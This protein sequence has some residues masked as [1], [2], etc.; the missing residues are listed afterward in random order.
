M[1]TEH[2][3]AN[4]RTSPQEKPT[5][6]TDAGPIADIVAALT[7][8]EKVA[9]MSG[10]DFY[11][12]FFGED[13][14]K[15]GV[16]VYT[17]GGGVE[18]LGLPDLHFTDGPRGVRAGKPTTCFPVSMAR[19]ASWDVDLE[20][21]IGLALGVE[22]RACGVTVSGAVCINVL[23]HPAWGRAQETY[24]ED[25]YHLGEMGAALSTGIQ[26]HNVIATVKHFAANSIENARFKVDVRMSERALREVYLPHFKRVIDSGCGSVM[27][28]YNK[29]NGAYCGHQ[30]HLLRDILKGEWGFEGFVHS[31]WVKGVYGHDA[32]AAGLDIENPDAFFFGANLIRAVR[33]G[34]IAEAVVD[35]AVTRILRT[36]RAINERPDERAY[37]PEDIC[38]P[39][40]RQLAREAAE[41]SMVLL[42]NEGLLPLRN[43]GRLAI[44]GALADTVNL[45]D[46]GSSNVTPPYAVTLLEGLRSSTKAPQDVVYDDGSDPAR[47]AALAADADAVVLV[48][49]YTHEDEGEFV[50]VPN[51]EALEEVESGDWS[52]A[53][54]GDRLSLDL[55][56]ADEALI[57]TVARANPRT[58]VAI[59]SGSAVTMNAWRDRP[60]AIMMTWY[61]GM[62][63]G[64]AFA[65][66]VYGEISPSGRLP[67]T[68]PE[69][70]QDL[71]YFDRDADRI[72]YG[73]YHGYTLMEKEGRSPAF[74]FGFGLTYTQFAYGEPVLED[75]GDRA[76]V[77]VEIRNIGSVEAVETVQLYAGFPHTAIDRSRKL[78][79]GFQRVRLAPG[80]SSIVAFEIRREDLSWYDP[81]A[82]A[83][84]V[85]SVD[86][87][88]HVGADSGDAQDRHVTW[89]H[90]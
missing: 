26:A 14:G 65:S 52:Q 81:D 66:L 51:E 63:G 12:R 88:L 41:K 34:E 39:A 13:G 44:I 33:E 86:H 57:D 56:P 7:L 42:K 8:E 1:L 83:W 58:L 6:I 27:T 29:V 90:A 16:R 22:S 77:R 73:L 15:F 46:R 75:K 50:P 11:N 71:P 19:G 89:R 55:K 21:R 5:P 25:P 84:R 31:D 37:G 53:R 54:G 85:E 49:G 24:G 30:T 80:A 35:E 20:H 38:A 67:F 78:L 60:A 2:A 36:Q 68:V 4:R 62:E 32:A 79:R 40:H 28:A 10:R 72:D 45:G 18:R 59:M 17:A 61:P 48:V 87:T 76:I 69:A 3:D 47:A 23:R 43:V 70:V 64:N 82:A 9:M 74:P